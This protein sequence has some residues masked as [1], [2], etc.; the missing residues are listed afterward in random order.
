[1]NTNEQAFVVG[2]KFLSKYLRNI[3]RYPLLFLKVFDESSHLDE[4]SV[5]IRILSF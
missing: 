3:F 2:V 1:M 4:T 5:A